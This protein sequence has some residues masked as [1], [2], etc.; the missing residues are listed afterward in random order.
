PGHG[1]ATLALLAGKR[2]VLPDLAF[3]DF[4]G[5]APRAEVVPVRIAESVIHFLTSSMTRGL[6]YAI[7]AGCDVLSISMGGVPARAWAAA[8][9]RAYE[10]GVAIFAAAGNRIGPSPP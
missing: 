8:V 5:G 1:T 2:V 3:D 6:D 10:A 7:E 9:N 4:L